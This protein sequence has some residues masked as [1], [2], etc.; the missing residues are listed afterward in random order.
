MCAPR[1]NA[2]MLFAQIDREIAIR[3]EPFHHA[4]GLRE[5]FGADPVARKDQHPLRHRA[6]IYAAARAAKAG[7]TSR[8]NSRIDVDACSKL[9]LPNIICAST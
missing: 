5:N 2:E 9:R 8:A 3:S 7:I 1:R 4:A 6:A